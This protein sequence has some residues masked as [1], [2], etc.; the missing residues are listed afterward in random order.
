MSTTRQVVATATTR[1]VDPY[2]EDLL[3]PLHDL[4]LAAMRTDT[5]DEPEPCALDLA[6]ALRFPWPGTTGEDFV[7]LC[8]GRPV[9]L[10]RLVFTDGTDACQIDTLVVHPAWRG[11]GVGGVL[12]ARAV[13]RTRANNRTRMTGRVPDT[14]VTGARQAAFAT[15]MGL[16]PAPGAAALVRSRLPLDAATLRFPQDLP[17]GYRAVH[18]GSALPEPHLEG[19]AAL[20]SFLNPSSPVP[21]HLAVARIRAM[22]TM[23][24]GRQRH[25]WQTGL[26]ACRTGQLVAWTSMTMTHSCPTHALQGTTVVHP[27][28][29]GRHLGL[30]VK[31]HN[32]A[33]ALRHERLL[34]R[35]DTLNADDNRHMI[36]INDAL[37]FEAVERRAAWSMTV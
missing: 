19:L 12:Y 11:R 20:E 23:R 5:P 32:L 1:P 36:R 8:E 31:R 21:A 24:A 27:A 2:A 14:P 22:E 4:L 6:G 9:G 30:L 28:H 17:H 26:V 33:H 35:V 7:A 15:A 37:G 16:R 3:D 29:R 13:E 10:L 34:R 25:A 18:L